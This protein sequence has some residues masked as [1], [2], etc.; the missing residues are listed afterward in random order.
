MAKLKDIAEA[1]G[2]SVVT[3]SNAL[4]GKKGVSDALRQ[5][6]L[7][8]AQELGYNVSRYDTKK[9]GTYSIGVIA[10]EEY[11][12]VGTSFYWYMYQQVAYAAAKKKCFTVFEILNKQIE[13][14]EKLPDVLTKG[15]VDGLLVIGWVNHRYIRRILD[16]VDIPVVLLDFYDPSFCC[17][18]VMSNN[19]LGMYKATRYLLERGHREIAFLGSVD[20]N[21]NIRD[22]FFGYRKALEEWK[23]PLCEEWIL[24][25]RDVGTLKMQVQ[26]PERMPTAFACS[27]DF[28][29]KYLYEELGSRGYRIPEDISIVGYDNY[30][31]GHPFAEEITTYNVDIRKMAKTAVSTLLKKIEDEDR[32]QG[33]RYLDSEIVERSSVKRLI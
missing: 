28:A 10:S 8:K 1:L 19:Y 2:I 20:A 27:S 5:E 14:P 25:D 6:V 18:A 15:E 22:R 33:V 26:L 17:D 4:S 23:I 21:D 9:T 11:L 7:D 12:G 24:E 3:V 16:A 32:Y 13:E 29:A 30:L 31:Y